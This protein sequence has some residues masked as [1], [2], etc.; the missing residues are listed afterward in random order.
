M[1]TFLRDSVSDKLTGCAY[2]RLALHNDAANMIS[3][4]PVDGEDGD[5]QAS[6]SLSER[7]Q[8]GVEGVFGC[9]ILGALVARLDGLRVETRCPSLTIIGDGCEG[10][11]SL[12]LLGY[13]PGPLRFAWLRED[14]EDITPAMRDKLTGALVSALRG[15]KVGKSMEPVSN[16]TGL[17]KVKEE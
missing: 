12:G 17:E 7:L 8:Q 16:S 3:A 1:G 10:R 6:W 13:H 9:D 15:E 11:P 4:Y 2:V 14:T 5:V